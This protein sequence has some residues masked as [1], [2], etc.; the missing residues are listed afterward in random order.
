MILNRP[1][2]RLI[3]RSVVVTNK[4]PLKVSR[5]AWDELSIIIIDRFPTYTSP[6]N[7]SHARTNGSLGVFVENVADLNTHFLASAS[8]SVLFK[9][10]PDLGEDEFEVKRFASV[11][12]WEKFKFN[13]RYSLV[14]RSVSRAFRSSLP[15]TISST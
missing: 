3:G 12:P 1:L 2:I 15:F 13:F 7:A 9:G 5:R 11:C 4:S 10:E 14:F 8:C 6:S